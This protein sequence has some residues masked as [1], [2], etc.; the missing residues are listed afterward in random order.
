MTQSLEKK[1]ILGLTLHSEIQQLDMEK[2]NLFKLWKEGFS[3]I[4]HFS[5][6][7]WNTLPKEEEDYTLGLYGDKELVMKEFPPRQSVALNPNNLLS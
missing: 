5:Y 1:L 2:V 4:D 7:S 6:S 3:G